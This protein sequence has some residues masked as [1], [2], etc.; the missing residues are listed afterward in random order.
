MASDL[1][2]LP[3][4]LACT[5]PGVKPSESGRESTFPTDSLVDSTRT[6]SDT[7]ESTQDS[8]LTEPCEDEGAYYQDVDGDGYGARR[9]WQ[10]EPAPGW[11]DLSG[12]CDDT[13]PDVHPG[14]EDVLDNDVDEDCD[15]PSSP[16][17]AFTGW[18]ASPGA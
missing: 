18:N 7:T 16:W 5:D 1:L 8:P 4:L 14:A 3:F 12:D 9:E 15:K 17:T 13:D 2:L 10:C 11:V 6:D